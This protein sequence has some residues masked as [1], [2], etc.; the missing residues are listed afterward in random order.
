MSARFKNQFQEKSVRPKP[1][2]H[3]KNTTLHNYM[4]DH[5]FKVFFK[6][7]YRQCLNMCFVHGGWMQQESS[8]R[9]GA[10]PGD[11][12]FVGCLKA[13]AQDWVEYLEPESQFEEVNKSLIGTWSLY[14]TPPAVWMKNILVFLV[15]FF[16]FV[17]SYLMHCLSVFFVDAECRKTETWGP[18]CNPLISAGVLWSLSFVQL[19]Y[20]LFG[21]IKSNFLCTSGNKYGFVWDLSRKQTTSVCNKNDKTKKDG[22]RNSLVGCMWCGILKSFV[23][24]S[25]S[26]LNLSH[27]QCGWVHQQAP[28]WSL[29]MTQK[30]V[31]KLTL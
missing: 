18:W 19:F 23:Q 5:S 22:K 12:G 1:P 30:T 17:V 3:V 11:C 2:L 25:R 21:T 26:Y 27:H 29:C 28:R 20:E 13:S 6:T 9:A 14:S 7:I 24:D 10:P 31:T 15:L 8:S 16:S 4:S